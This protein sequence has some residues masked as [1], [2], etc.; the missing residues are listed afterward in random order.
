MGN[1]TTIQAADKEIHIH[2]DSSTVFTVMEYPMGTVFDQ[3]SALPVQFDLQKEREGC[4]LTLDRFDGQRDR[5]YAQ[6]TVL[7][8]GEP[9]Q[10]PSCVNSFGMAEWDYPYPTANTIKGLQIRMVADAV[11]LGVK[12][13]ALNVSQPVIMLSEPSDDTE[14]FVSNGKTYYFRKS[15]MAQFDEKVKALSDNG[16]VVNLILLNSM[17]WDG[18]QAEP[19]IEAIVAHPHYDRE[20]FISAFNTVT[21]QGLAYYIAFVA[22]LAQRYMAAD[23][24]HGRAC[25]LIIGNEVDSQWVWGNAGRMTVEQYMAEYTVAL[26]LA[27]LAARKYYKYAR[28][29]LSLDHFW[30]MRY[31]DDVLQSYSGKAVLDNLLDYCQ[32]EGDFPWGLAHHPY[33]EDLN[34]PDF[35]HD[36]TA[37]CRMD[38]GRITFKNL[39]VLS[40]YFNE[41]ALLYEGKQRP[42]ILSEQG[43]NSKETDESEALQSAA[44]CLAYKKVQS[45]PQIESFILHAHVDNKDE[46]GLNLGIVRRNKQSEQDDEPGEPK[47]VYEAFKGIDGPDSARICKEA[48]TYIGSDIWDDVLN[49]K[50]C[51]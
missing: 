25:G 5:L 51:K 13:A 37:V 10:G 12:H 17:K 44:Y 23:A 7:A 21:S 14:S 38:T 41:P 40:T 2:T 32:A 35:W 6:F 3:A 28:V 27:Y 16:I 33:P 26:R 11:S 18:L 22:F 1:I 34:N 20:G 36:N 19:A 9:L 42:I 46:F 48:R 4:T 8:D 24:A 30:T 15:Y 49:N 47:P 45:I 29:Y 50:E 39:E 43:F 31:L